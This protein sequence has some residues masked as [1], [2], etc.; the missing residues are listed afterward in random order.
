MGK[1]SGIGRGYETGLYTASDTTWEIIFQKRPRVRWC[2]TSVLEY[3][4]QLKKIFG[5]RAASGQKAASIS[6]L[7][8]NTTTSN[9][10]FD[11]RLA[12]IAAEQDVE[13]DTQGDISYLGR[14]DKDFGPLSEEEESVE[15]T[16]NRPQTK[17]AKVH[18]N[19]GS[20]SK[21]PNQSTDDTSSPPKITKKK[22]VG[23]ELANQM[24]EWRE[25][26]EKEFEQR[27]LAKLSPEAQVIRN[28]QEHYAEEVEKLSYE[29]YSQLVLLLRK[30]HQ[31]VGGYTG[32]E[33]YTMMDGR[34]AKFLD[35]LMR[36]WF[37]KIKS[38]LKTITPL[39]PSE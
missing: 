35:E 1:Q 4:Q 19:T 21:D 31:E 20:L 9:D 11:P 28:I 5:R 34:N 26:C 36:K 33:Y 15:E 12:D 25:H 18:H 14:I 38:Q 13:R 17:K 3:E 2:R 8:N 6:T 22:N 27:E 7:R 16:D 24:K 29:E 30:P 37:E 23:L 39:P 10:V 32:A